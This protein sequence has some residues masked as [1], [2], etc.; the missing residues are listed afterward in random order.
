MAQSTVL[1]KF[2]ALPPEAQQQVLDFIAILE[3][4][5]RTKAGRQARVPLTEEAF[6][7]IW[8]SRSDMQDSAAWVRALREAEW[9]R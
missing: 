5:Y 9:E 6:V 1:K 7:G 8:K 2:N 4:R 3:K